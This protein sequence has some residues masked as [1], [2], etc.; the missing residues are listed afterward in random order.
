MHESH[1]EEEVRRVLREEI[2]AG[3]NRKIE[4]LDASSPP[5]I[6]GAIL[7]HI[8]DQEWAVGIQAEAWLK[9]IKEKTG[10][11]LKF[12]RGHI[13]NRQREL[14]GKKETNLT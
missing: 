10:T 14:K 13:K 3:I 11:E 4:N 1:T 7:D 2:R 9:A 8:A 12:M 5:A 6:I